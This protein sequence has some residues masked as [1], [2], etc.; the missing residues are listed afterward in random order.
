VRL[1]NQAVL[2]II[3]VLLE[4]L[5][6]CR[7]KRREPTFRRALYLVR[8]SNTVRLASLGALFCISVPRKIL[9]YRVL[10]AR[11]TTSRRAERRNAEILAK[12][13]TVIEATQHAIRTARLLLL[14]FMM[15]LIFRFLTHHAKF[16]TKEILVKTRTAASLSIVQSLASGNR[17]LRLTLIRVSH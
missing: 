8:S 15:T 5:R 12:S 9:R 7:L 6:Y 14:N 4:T 10:K 3:S 11:K 17:T 13:L 1:E 16:A 2:F